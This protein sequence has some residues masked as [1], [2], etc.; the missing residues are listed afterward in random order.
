MLPI[1]ELSRFFEGTGQWLG[2]I[3]SK[4]PLNGK[5]LWTLLPLAMDLISSEK[6]LYK[7]ANSYFDCRYDD[8]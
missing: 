8:E 3:L 5:L 6:V 4:A 7:Y 1:R 2:V